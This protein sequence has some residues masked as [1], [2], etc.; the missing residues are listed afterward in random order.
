MRKKLKPLTGTLVVIFGLLHSVSFGE[1]AVPRKVEVGDG[2]GLHYLEQGEGDPII[3]I[4]GLTGDYS[5]WTRQLEAFAKE[6]YR[7]IAY[8]R[9]YNYPNKNRLRP[10]HSAIVEAE[11]LAAFMIKLKLKNAHIVGFSYGAYTALMLALEHP[12]MV[13]TVTLAEPPISLWLADLPGDD[14]E[15]GKAHL[16]RLMNEGVRPA[17]A[18]F[19][20]GDDEAGM[21]TMFDCIA[22]K[23]SFD[24]LPKFV[25]DR[26]WRNIKEMKAIVSSKNIYPNV[27]R[28]RVRS[29]GVP[30]LI[31]S[32][33]ESHA[34]AK[35][36][37]S[38]LERLIPENSRKRVVLRG[39]THIMWVEQPVQSRNAVLEFIR[40]K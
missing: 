40:E 31:L 35:F 2:V 15:A 34:V 12:E 36:T 24:R 25:K 38:E 20:S 30:T 6:G 26:C 17:K 39:A 22:A 14:A 32:G 7:A 5:D 8:S 11:D 18:A 19:D 1:E 28:D 33:S 3:F 9:R 37:D 13:R 10:D 29:M 23:A 21:R 4:H 16:K 27:E